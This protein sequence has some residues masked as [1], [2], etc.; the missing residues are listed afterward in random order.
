MVTVAF[1][2]SGSSGNAT[3]VRSGDTQLLLDCGFSARET[4]RR[5]TA[6]GIDANATNEVLV[7]HEHSDHVS[8]VPVFARRHHVPVFLSDGTARA[9]G[10]PGE[11]GCEL[12]RVRSGETFT[13]GSLRVTAFRVSHDAAEPL[14]YLFEDD[15]G[16]RLGIATDTGVATGELLEALTGC[17]VLGIETNHDAEMLQNGP[18]PYFL[19][20]RIAGERGH[21]DNRAAADIVERLA[22][23]GLRRVVGLHVS[24]HNNTRVLAAASL[25][26]TLERLGLE[27]SVDVASQHAP[28]RPTDGVQGRLAL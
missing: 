4:A 11:R 15:E 17:H 24:Q 27:V 7:T 23:D 25:K 8:G 9:S 13:V 1:L 21:L 28:L 18:Y 22:H 2:G 5:M 20:R 26:A 16:E 6:L 12:H 19:R 14:G 10:L 3:V